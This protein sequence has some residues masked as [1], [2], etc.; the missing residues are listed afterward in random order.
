MRFVLVSLFF[1]AVT[2]PTVSQTTSA[3]LSSSLLVRQVEKQLID[4][5]TFYDLFAMLENPREKFSD[6]ESQWT[7]YMFSDDVATHI[8]NTLT[9]LAGIPGD[10]E[11]LSALDWP[12]EIKPEISLALFL[13]HTDLKIRSQCQSAM[14]GIVRKFVEQ[15]HYGVIELEHPDMGE[16]MEVKTELSKD[17]GLIGTSLVEMRHANYTRDISAEFAIFRDFAST[18]LTSLTDRLNDAKHSAEQM[19]EFQYETISHLL[20]VARGLHAFI[21]T[22]DLEIIERL[23]G[24]AM[25]WTYFM[26]RGTFP[27]FLQRMRQSFEQV[28]ELIDSCSTTFVPI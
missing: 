6:D 21:P 25:G 16:I 12:S 5:E 17:I 27:A 9:S 23:L 24:Q 13:L 7:D 4:A 2:G 11:S 20:S 8:N 19:E 3:F 15:L 14:C 22:C 18:R 28:E 26:V 10:R 1:V